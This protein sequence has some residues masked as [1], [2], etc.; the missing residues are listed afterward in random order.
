MPKGESILDKEEKDDKEM[1]K[2]LKDLTKS[3]QKIKR[4]NWEPYKEKYPELYKEEFGS[5]SP[6][7]TEVEKMRDKID[8]L[9][10]ENMRLK[11]YIK[12]LR[13]I[14]KKKDKELQTKDKEITKLKDTK[15][16]KNI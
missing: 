11:D 12:E 15:R 2:V 4:K 3:V 13:K 9:T 8:S 1:E 14:D 7:H 16:G 6:I 5:L 10:E